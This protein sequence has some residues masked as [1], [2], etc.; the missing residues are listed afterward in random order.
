MASRRQ[1]P[2]DGRADR[3]IDDLG[4]G[5]ALTQTATTSA[6][7]AQTRGEIDVQIATAHRFPRSL[8]KVVQEATSLITSDTEVAASCF[9]TL[10]RMRKDRD[11]K[12]VPITGPSVRLAEIIASSWGNLRVQARPI[13]DNGTAV[14]SQGIA[15]DLEKNYAISV[16]TRRR[17][18]DKHGN[19]YSDDM[20]AMTENA[21]TS[22][23]K[24]NAI[25]NVI[26]RAVVEKLDR[27]ARQCAV[28]E[29]KTLTERRERALKWFAEQ[30]VDEN[31]VCSAVDIAG[32]EDIDLGKLEQLQGIRTAIMEKIATIDE[33]FP[34]S[35]PPTNGT[36]K[37]GPGGTATAKTSSDEPPH[38]PKTGEVTNSSPETSQDKDFE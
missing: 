20:V 15:W 35:T 11:G 24:R 26:P 8:T 4:V 19:R 9:Y 2:R 16:E 34:P 18:T 22:V 38:D 32:V 31:R 14:T 17:I 37:V 30:G 28:G 10:P 3:G 36:V 6:L 13:D 5:E 23:A 27:T 1:D 12:S 7:E 25:L 29:V 33:C 21:N